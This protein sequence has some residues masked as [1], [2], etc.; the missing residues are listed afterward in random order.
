MTT[1]RV[2]ALAWLIP[3]LNAAS[4]ALLAQTCTVLARCARDNMSYRT[5]RVLK[6]TQERHHLHNTEVCQ[7]LAC[8]PTFQLTYGQTCEFVEGV[9]TTLA[10]GPIFFKACPFASA[11]TLRR[12]AEAKRAGYCHRC[13]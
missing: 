3:E 7:W 2:E 1:S 8:A 11:P 5:Q 13:Q 6:L 9:H 4:V 10:S 12:V